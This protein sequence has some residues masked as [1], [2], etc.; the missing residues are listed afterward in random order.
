MRIYK[1]GKVYWLEM[2]RDCR[3]YQRSLKTE[4]MEVAQVR[5][6]EFVRKLD[7]DDLPGGERRDPHELAREFLADKQR[8][9][10]AESHRSS[11]E[12]RLGHM[13]DGARELRDVNPAWIRKKLVAVRGGARNQNLYRLA[14][15]GLYR[16]LIRQGVC[17]RNPCDAVEPA[18]VVYENHRRALTP[19][20]VDRLLAVSPDYRRLVYLVALNTGLR[21]TELRLLRWR[22]VD[23]DGRRL[24]LDGELV[25]NRRAAVLPLNERAATEL[26]AWKAKNTG[27]PAALVWAHGFPIP[28]TVR[29]DFEAAGIS[30][31]T[32]DGRCDLHAL[33]VTFC[34]R[35]AE[36]GV[37][38][39]TAKELMRHSSVALTSK[40][41][42]RVSLDSKRS[43]VDSI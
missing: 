43:A 26:A 23:L 35:L 16:W 1:R 37:H 13:L 29:G 33:R 41:Y 17:D 39:Q 20:E 31:I 3:R 5:A 21:R 32:A 22:H 12:H 36:A 10:C 18:Q 38:M 34:T 14:L 28:R 9:G 2:R 8:R 19:E 24:V 4:S 30:K 15:S 25:K 7:R 40:V 6:A 11:L 27:A 42:T